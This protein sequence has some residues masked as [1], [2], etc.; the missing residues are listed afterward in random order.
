MY[1]LDYSLA[2]LHILCPTLRLSSVSW[3]HL[4]TYKLS[5][6]KKHQFVDHT[7]SC[8]VQKPNP[9]H[10]AWQPVAQ[11][12]RQPYKLY[13]YITNDLS[14]CPNFSILKLP[15]V[16]AFTN[17]QV[18]KQITLIPATTICE[19]HKEMLR[20][21]RVMLRH[22]WADSTGVIPMQ[23]TDVKQRLRC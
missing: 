23:Q 21:G 11:L 15:H 10:V 17:I 18:H 1:H 13:A 6:D 3:V 7:K 20:C 8:S 2:I 9:L 5:L 22:E 14:L 19:S 4:Q 12:L 16:G